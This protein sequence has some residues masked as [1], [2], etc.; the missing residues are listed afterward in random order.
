M[1]VVLRQ[2]YIH[3]RPFEIHNT[4]LTLWTI[5]PN[6]FQDDPSINSS[7]FECIISLKIF[8]RL[9]GYIE[10]LPY[11]VN[12]FKDQIFITIHIAIYAA[13]HPWYK[14]DPCCN[15]YNNWFGIRCNRSGKEHEVRKKPTTIRYSHP[16]NV[17]Y[18]M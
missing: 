1:S 13:K 7:V 8:W 5:Y 11:I 3:F 10:N 18:D 14:D 17:L 15:S 9:E 4:F 16:S 2:L 12:C 6:K